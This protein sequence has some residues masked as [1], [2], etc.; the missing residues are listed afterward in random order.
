MRDVILT[1]NANEETSDNNLKMKR[2]ASEGSLRHEEQITSEGRR[3]MAMEY[4]FLIFPSFLK[5]GAILL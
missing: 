5:H 3:E 2:N 1:G 4:F